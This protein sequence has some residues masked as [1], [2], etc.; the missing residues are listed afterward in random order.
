[1]L[2]NNTQE[3]EGK[4][5]MEQELDMFGI[6]FSLYKVNT[7]NQFNNKNVHKFQIEITL[8]NI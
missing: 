5:I 1:M 2:I 7:I 4:S 3:N 8:L 6:P